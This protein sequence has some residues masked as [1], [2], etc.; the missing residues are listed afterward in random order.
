MTSNTSLAAFLSPEE[1]VPLQSRMM[2]ILS[3]EIL[4]YTNGKSSSVST[5]TAQNLLE[6]MLYCITAY[7]DTLPDPSA[8]LQTRDLGELYQNGLELVKRYVEECKVLLEEVKAT[9]VQTDLIAYNTTIDIDIDQLLHCYNPRFEAQNTTPLST[10]AFIEYPLSK[11]DMSITGIIYIKNYLTQL[12]LENQFC[13]KYS[14]NY[15]RSLLFT[16]GAKHHLD[17]R[18]MLVNI[19]E[20][21]LEHEKRA[22]Q[23]TRPQ[24]EMI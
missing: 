16:H 22:S 6:S 24:D 3:E 7:L 17:Y 23:K 12:K 1:I 13:A 18:E 19:P 21:I 5:E 4:Y 11:D 9:R 2:Q 8:A 15:I 14:K 10:T 20:I